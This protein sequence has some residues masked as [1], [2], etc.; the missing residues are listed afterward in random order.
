MHIMI[1]QPLFVGGIEIIALIGIIVLLFG[2]SKIPKLAR[3][4]GKATKEFERGRQQ[5]EEEVERLKE[6]LEAEETGDQTDDV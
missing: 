3:S 2:A 6:E 5:S 1:S 4:T